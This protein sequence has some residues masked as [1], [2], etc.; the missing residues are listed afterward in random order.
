MTSSTSTIKLQQSIGVTKL[1]SRENGAEAVK[2]GKPRKHREE[3]AVG[4]QSFSQR[5]TALRESISSLRGKISISVPHPYDPLKFTEY[6]TF[7]RPTVVFSGPPVA[8]TPLSE[9][10]LRARRA[11]TFGYAGS[12]SKGSNFTSEVKKEERKAEPVVDIHKH[13]EILHKNIKASEPL[14][15]TT[16]IATKLENGK[17]KRRVIPSKPA[18]K[19]T[20]PTLMELEPLMLLFDTIAAPVSNEDFPISIDHTIKSEESPGSNEPNDNSRSSHCEEHVDSALSPPPECSMEV[21]HSIEQEVKISNDGPTVSGVCHKDSP[22]A[23]D[24]RKR[25]SSD[26]ERE[27]KSKRLKTSDYGI[28]IK[29]E[30][31]EV[32]ADVELSVNVDD[33]K[34]L[35]NGFM[36]TSVP[37]CKKKDSELTTE[38][39]MDSRERSITNAQVHE[40]LKPATVENDA[41]K[42]R[43]D[44][45]K[46]RTREFETTPEKVKIEN[47]REIK[48]EKEKDKKKEKD[49]KDGKDGRDSKRP[50][51]NVRE[52]DR[53]VRDKDRERDRGS[54]RSRSRERRDRD[55]ERDRERSDRTRETSRERSRSREHRDK[56]R[57]RDRGRPQSRERSRSRDREKDRERDRGRDFSRDQSRSRERDRDRDRGREKREDRHGGRADTS[58]E[59]RK[60][61]QGQDAKEDVKRTADVVVVVTERESSVDPFASSTSPK[62]RQQNKDGK[63]KDPY[64]N[65]AP[66]FDSMASPGLPDATPNLT[67]PPAS[68]RVMSLMEYSLRGN[69]SVPERLSGED[70]PIV[71]TPSSIA[72]KPSLQIGSSSGGNSPITPNSRQLADQ[73]GSGSK[74]GAGSLSNPGRW[75]HLGLIHKHMGDDLNKSKDATRQILSALHYCA[76]L[77]CHALDLAAKSAWSK[78]DLLVIPTF[79]S[80]LGYVYL[81]F[82]KLK[83][84]GLHSL[85][86]RFES[87]LLFKSGKRRL[88]FTAGYV[89]NIPPTS[90]DEKKTVDWEKKTRELAKSFNDAWH[91]T[92]KSELRWA[93]ASKFCRVLSD[94]FPRSSENI[95]LSQ[96][97]SLTVICEF[98]W[99]CIE[100]YAEQKGLDF[101]FK[102]L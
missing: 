60:K 50:R 91:D 87:V 23:L 11:T 52:R 17:A 25:V 48:V 31:G 57:E 42:S 59:D 51:D 68:K 88:A 32:T 78:D 70:T 62:S 89:K 93:D 74:S 46:G 63:K 90:G 97:M 58:R 24:I 84:T 43:R 1:Q 56:D 13:S 14:R 45:E 7:V 41:K 77:V 4:S 27:S 21:D 82:T 34:N 2:S 8:G 72:R 22:P 81:R 49:G 92:Q 15:T 86:L 71:D 26:G 39:G 3:G 36:D 35:A 69:A 37:S 33:S 75:K 53:G 6:R 94:E 66:K 102:A 64:Q 10:E 54:D 76:S 79:D 18:T 19:N 40:D 55:R 98:C 101:K 5:A 16:P 67:H 29:K 44:R 96:D 65:A 47:Q 38:N 83:L 61:R 30:P 100:E 99:H 12:G 9:S 73:Q 80:M 20:A 28:E 85:M 95:A